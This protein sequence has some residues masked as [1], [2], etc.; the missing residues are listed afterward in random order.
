M[1]PPHQA[2]TLKP[3]Q[4][5]QRA[6]DAL[7]LPADPWIFDGNAD[8]WV[9][10]EMSDKQGVSGPAGLPNDLM[11]AEVPLGVDPAASGETDHRKL[12]NGM[13]SRDPAAV[14]DFHSGSTGHHLSPMSRAFTKRAEEQQRAMNKSSLTNRER[15]LM[16]QAFLAGA[17]VSQKAAQPGGFD[18]IASMLQSGTGEVQWDFGNSLD[19]SDN[20]IPSISTFSELLNAN[21]SGSSTRRDG[22]VSTS[23]QGQS[24]RC[25]Q[26][27]GSMEGGDA[28]LCGD[29]RHVPLSAGTV[30]R[31]RA[32][33]TR[34]PAA[35]RPVEARLRGRQHPPA[36][37]QGRAHLSMPAPRASHISA[38]AVAHHS[39]WGTSP[40]VP[41]RP[42]KVA[43][44]RMGLPLLSPTAAKQISGEFRLGN[45][46]AEEKERR[47]EISFEH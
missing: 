23:Q 42:N 18:A 46:T 3:I 27:L 34:A 14:Q 37:S 11:G 36:S 19:T 20:S 4:M 21:S 17:A 39:G 41:L 12:L 9:A 31:E 44:G 43:S 6:A 15:Q 16:H 30:H 26:A 22:H 28:Q 8:R 1:P 29:G 2:G 7:L 33:A 35:A 38:A 25:L 45:I 40:M 5:K 24:W 47:K 13:F 32:R 10:T